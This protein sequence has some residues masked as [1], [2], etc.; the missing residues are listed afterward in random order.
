MKFLYLS[1]DGSSLH[2]GSRPPRGIGTAPL[3]AVFEDHYGVSGESSRSPTCLFSISGEAIGIYYPDSR[4]PF[5]L[6]VEFLR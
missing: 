6:D 1:P 4:L 3:S 2:T 5:Q